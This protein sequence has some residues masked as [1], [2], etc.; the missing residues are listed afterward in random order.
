[1]RWPTRVSIKYFQCLNYSNINISNCFTSQVRE[2]PKRPNRRWKRF[3]PFSRFRTSWPLKPSRT[4][5][6]W[7]RG[8]R[9]HS[10][11]W[12]KRKGPLKRLAGLPTQLK[13]TSHP[14]VVA[15]RD[16]RAVTAA[17]RRPVVTEDRLRPA[18]TLVNL[19]LVVIEGSH[20]LVD[21]I[22]YLWSTNI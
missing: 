8:S 17:I 15:E 22:P 4:Q 21:T 6:S 3:R 16:L 19:Q 9:T 13:T 7:R 5:S 11:T 18:V 20:R 10:M 1:M 14:L 2:T 12:L